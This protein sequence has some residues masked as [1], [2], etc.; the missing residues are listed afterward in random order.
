MAQKC[1]K[2]AILYGP[3]GPFTVEE[4]FVPDPLPGGMLLKV[5]LCGICG[6]DVHIFKGQMLGVPFPL[7]IGHEPVC[8]IEALGEGEHTDFNG[9]PLKVGDRVY[10]IGLKTC[11]KCYNCTIAFEPSACY[12]GMGYSAKP[13]PDEPPHFQG[14]Y[15]Q[16]IDIKPGFTGIFKVDVDKPE[17]AIMLEPLGVGIHAVDCAEFRVPSTVVIQGAGATALGTMIAAKEAGATKII[18]IGAPQARLEVAREFGADLVINIDDVKDPEER[19]RMVKNESWFGLGADIVFEATGVPKALLEGIA[20]MRNSG[21]FIT[22]GHFTDNGT[23]EFNPFKHFTNNQI[24]LRGVW[25]AAHHHLARAVYI[26]ESGK[27]KLEKMVSHEV[28][29]EKVGNV[30]EQLTKGMIVDG[31]EACKVAVAPWK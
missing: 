15:S 3:G 10:L 18:V 8:V 14:G 4:A 2:A 28:P 12:N 25:G 7:V 19:I 24:T 26:V 20:M 6:T 27:Y 16:Y 1:G 5:E 22:L 17:R 9:R 23:A 13:F 11:G 21:Q 31:K 29:L 30:V